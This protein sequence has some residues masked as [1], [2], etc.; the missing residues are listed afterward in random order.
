MSRF[1]ILLLL[2]PSLIGNAQSN[3]NKPGAITVTAYYSG[4]ASQIDSYPVEKLTHIIYSFCH[5]KGLRLS[6]DN[7]ADSLTIK[8][9]VALKSRNRQ[10]KVLLSLGGWGGCKDCSDA[11]DTDAKRRTFAASVKEVNDYFKTDG[12]DLDWEYPA[13]Q[14]Y[15]EHH[16]KPEDKQNFTALVRSLRESLG[17]KNEISFAAGGFETFLKESIEW[18]KVTP[19][20]DRINLMSYDLVNGYSQVTGHHTPLYSNASQQE[21]ADFAI[22]YLQRL[23]VPPGKIVIGAA[24]YARTWEGVSD[25]ANGLYQSGKFKSFVPFN[26]FPNNLSIEKGFTFY[27]DSIA[28]AGYAY[29]KQTK[30]FA[31]FDDPRS[32]AEKT[33]YAQQKGLNGIMFW[34]LTLDKP[35]NGLLDVI[36]DTLQQH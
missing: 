11:F 34:E 1:L 3:Q 30:T 17:N 10:L 9:L 33:R 19:L 32:I 29:N 18:D 24:F 25:S 16:F 26:Q 12:L 27:Y 35:R 15:P 6:V 20:V 31:T 23:G 7:A 36:H 28:R 5:L 21:S 13:I 14:G 4:N 8:Q 22:N 2:L